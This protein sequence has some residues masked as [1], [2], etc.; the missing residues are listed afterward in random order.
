MTLKII[1]TF[2]FKFASKRAT[3]GFNSLNLKFHFARIVI[4]IAIKEKVEVA[5][6]RS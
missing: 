6:S 3:C 1:I 5:G 4:L 2:P